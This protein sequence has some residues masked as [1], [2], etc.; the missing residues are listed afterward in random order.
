MHVLQTVAA[1]WDQESI[2]EI[3]EISPMMRGSTNHE[4]QSHRK[5]TWSWTNL[6]CKN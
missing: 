5:L 2:A 4:E 1:E 3:F 6:L